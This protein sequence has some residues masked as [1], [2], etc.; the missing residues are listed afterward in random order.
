MVA[1]A[2]VATSLLMPASLALAA[3]R[4]KFKAVAF[5]AFPI[6]DP[7]PVFVLAE[8][9]FPGKG[10]DLSNTWRTR[11][12][13]YTW[14]RTVSHRYA[15]F[16]KVT[17]DALVFSARTLQLDLTSEK[18][19][20]LMNAYLEL[21]AYPDVLPA[22]RLLRDAG[23][24]L[25]F[26]SNMTSHMLD[27]NIKNSNLDGI[28]E[29]VLSTDKVRAYKPDPRAYQM[30]IDALCLNVNEVVFAAFA[31]WDTVGA[32]WFGYPTF[33]VNRL[34]SP[35]EQLDVTPDASATNLTELV[36]FVEA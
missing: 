20:K 24:R 7:R 18:R 14:L 30:G 10:P 29:H 8:K 35:V 1:T 28:F 25:A 21:E 22:L 4:P 33:W 36:R 27:A 12:F 9:L 15:D 11:Q 32:K 23:V 17:E 16:W 5:D 19:E 6:F 3:S 34:N 2:G 31:G 26:L 13:E